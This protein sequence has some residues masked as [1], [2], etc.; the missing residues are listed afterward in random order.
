M[1]TAG[2]VI[3]R[4]TL[5]ATMGLGCLAAAQIGSKTPGF[6]LNDTS[7]KIHDL[8]NYA[9]KI[10]V[11]E[12]WSFKCPVALAYDDRMAVLQAQYRDRGV[13]FLA[14]SSNKNESPQEIKSNAENLKLPF[15]V[16]LDQDGA[17]A[18]MVG[19]THTPSV[20]LLD[21]S[22]TIRYRGAIDNNK[23]VNQSGRI[24]YLDAALSSLIAGQSVA[25]P[26]TAVFGCSI[27]R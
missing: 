20:V 23:R 27:R 1:R 2:R 24:A 16:L 19:A 15:P 18:E 14:V 25:Q 21:G 7:G 5:L 12:F 8:E 17:V 26:E 11:L 6:R 13:V 10:V 22:G 3:M 9:G 4:L